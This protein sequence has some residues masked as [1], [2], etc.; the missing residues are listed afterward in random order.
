MSN[1]QTDTDPQH[2]TDTPPAGTAD[3]SQSPRHDLEFDNYSQDELRTFIGAAMER[4]EP[5]AL[6]DVISHAQTLIRSKEEEA[7]NQL[8]EKWREEAARFGYQVRL[9]PI[10][11]PQSGQRRSRGTGAASSVAPKY[12][13]PDGSTWSGRGLKPKW[14][15]SLLAQGHNLEEFRIKEGDA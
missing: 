11:S 6:P 8:L 15:E 9:E 10:G 4:L 7:R 13:G 5:D 2:E 12:R 3:G 14:L 1:T